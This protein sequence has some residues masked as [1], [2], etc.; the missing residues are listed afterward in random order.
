MSASAATRFARKTAARGAVL[1]APLLLT[2]CQPG[3]P[4]PA[5]PGRARRAHDPDRLARHHAGHR[6]CRRSSRPSPSP[7][8]S[9]PPTPAPA[10][11]PTGSIPARIELVV[12]AIPL[13][14][15]MLLGGV[16]WIGSHDLD[17]AKPLVVERE[18][19]L[20]IQVVSLDWKWLFIYPGQRV[21]S[22]NQLVVPGGRAAALLAHLGERDERLL[23]AAARQHDLHDERHDGPS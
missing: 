7:G 23:R 18:A 5:R 19:P 16:A 2:A 9:A 20:E 12:W 4:R 22:V 21:A 10:T 8:G 13:L 11:C 14:V 6:A 15:I 17:P 3:R 1:A